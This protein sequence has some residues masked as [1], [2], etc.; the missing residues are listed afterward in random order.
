MIV[1]FGSLSGDHM[2]SLP[3]L[4]KPGETGLATSYALL[5][6]GKGANQAAAAGKC[7]ADVVMCGCV[8]DDT[9]GTMAR[10]SLES[11]GVRCE[12]L[13][14]VAGEPTGLAFVW[15]DSHAEN[16]ITVAPNANGLSRAVD[17]AAFLQKR[18]GALRAHA[19]VQMEV[20][21]RENWR[22]LALAKSHGFTTVCNLA[23]EMPIPKGAWDSL[24]VLIVNEHEAASLTDGQTSRNALQALARQ[25]CLTLIVTEGAQGATAFSADGVVHVD[26][27]PITPVDTTGA[28]D[29]FVG[30]FV[31]RLDAGD[32]LGDALRYAAVAGG[33]ACLAHGAQ[34]A[35]PTHGDVL[36]KL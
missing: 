35:L 32:T 31:A 15:V 7:G 29:A 19:L 21:A 30:A 36:A 34:S 13:R 6:G 10:R 33:L 5:P 14:T 17:A 27:M 1:V 3:H 16:I 26:A 20:P 22:F 24:D 23:P 4:P 12:G 25:R 9:A 2:V 28:G 8:G 18:A 11:A